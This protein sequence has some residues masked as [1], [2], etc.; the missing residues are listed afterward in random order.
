MEEDDVVVFHYCGF[1]LSSSFNGEHVDRV[2]QSLLALYNGI[3][4]TGE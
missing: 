3:F 4:A 2:P 1:N